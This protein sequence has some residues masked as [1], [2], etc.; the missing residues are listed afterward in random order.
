MSNLLNC[1]PYTRHKLK[2]FQDEME[3]FK[4]WLDKKVNTN[5]SHLRPTDLLSNMRERSV[6]ASSLQIPDH[7]KWDE[8]FSSDLAAIA[9]HKMKES[10]EGLLPTGFVLIA[11]SV[12]FGKVLS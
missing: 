7:F 6:C 5:V 12:D 4:Q 10:I 2:H 11:T 3:G 9:V 8:H 1:D